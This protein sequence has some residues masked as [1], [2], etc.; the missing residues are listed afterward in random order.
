MY[1]WYMTLAPDTDGPIERTATDARAHFSDVVG[2]AQHAGVTTAIT[3]NGRRVAAVVPADVL[4][5]LDDLEDRALSRMAAEALAEDD[6]TR[7]SLDQVRAEI[8][9]DD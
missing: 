5:L 9:G 2:L 8:L 7:Y 6:G 4:D 1:I 3:R